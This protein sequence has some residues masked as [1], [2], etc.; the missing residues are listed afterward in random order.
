MTRPTAAI[1]LVLIACAQPRPNECTPEALGWN[2]DGACFFNPPVTFFSDERQNC[3]PP[4]TG[5]Q[6]LTQC[7]D[8]VEFNLSTAVWV[9]GDVMINAGYD[10]EGN[11]ITFGEGLDGAVWDPTSGPLTFGGQPYIPMCHDE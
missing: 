9:D 4:I 3:G 6:S 7:F 1:A 11:A 2:T 5:V 10:C 8:T